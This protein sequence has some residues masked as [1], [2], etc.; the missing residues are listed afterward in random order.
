MLLVKII[1]FLTRQLLLLALAV[2]YYHG[3]CQYKIKILSTDVQQWSGWAVKYENLEE[4]QKDYPEFLPH[5]CPRETRLPIDPKLK[6]GYDD[7]SVYWESR[8]GLYS[9]DK[10][11]EPKRIAN[12]LEC[13]DTVPTP[14]LSLDGDCFLHHDHR[15]GLQKGIYYINQMDG[16]EVC[17]E[18]N[19]LSHWRFH[20]NRGEGMAHSGV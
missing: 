13:P 2:M 3:A 18:K 19:I 7:W 9:F 8:D 15:R 14:Y 16:R 4:I 17:Y 10:I 20:Q 12:V 6:E 11:Y 5:V 1:L